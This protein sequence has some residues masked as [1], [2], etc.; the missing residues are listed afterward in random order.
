MI[1]TKLHCGLGN[2][3]FQYAAGL[4]LAEKHKTTLKL[5]VSWFRQYEGMADHNRYGLSCFNICEQFAT[6]EEVSLSQEKHSA[7]SSSYYK[8]FEALPN[9]AFI[10]GYFQAPHFFAPIEPLLRLHYS[11]K[12]SLSAPAQNMSGIIRAASPSVFLC[13]RRGDYT[14]N[15]QNSLGVLGWDFYLAALDLLK[16]KIGNFTAFIFSDDIDAIKSENRTAVSCVYVDAKIASTAFDQLHLMS[17]CDHAIIANSTFAWWGAWL[18][19]NPEK[20]VI[21]PDPWFVGKEFSQLD[22]V[23][24]SWLRISARHSAIMPSF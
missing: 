14:S 22:I 15:Y 2:Q 16:S 10:S 12:Y 4:A 7:P 8:D 6:E 18:I 9:G 11:F 3:M 5:D 23:P 13:F 19:E 17:L 1:I 20:I 24:P 21:A